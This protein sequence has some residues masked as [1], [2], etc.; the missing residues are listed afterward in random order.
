MTAQLTA[1]AT[2]RGSGGPDPKKTREQRE[3]E[4]IGMM[5]WRDG[6]DIIVALY[7]EAEGIPLG[8]GPAAGTS[9]RFEMIPSILK[10]EYPAN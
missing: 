8:Q 3:Q 10:K 4:L 6:L 1:Q 5:K 9:T 2:H 7:Q